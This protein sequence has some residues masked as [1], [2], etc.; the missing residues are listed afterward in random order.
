[1]YSPTADWRCVLSW[2]TL[3]PE[4]TTTAF[5]KDGGDNRVTMV[6]E[7]VGDHLAFY[8]EGGGGCLPN[9]KICVWYATGKHDYARPCTDWHYCFWTNWFYPVRVNTLT[10]DVPMPLRFVDWNKGHDAA[11]ERAFPLSR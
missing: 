11:Y 3:C 10:P 2:T 1:M 6:G 5:L 9:S 4:I 7:P 8:A